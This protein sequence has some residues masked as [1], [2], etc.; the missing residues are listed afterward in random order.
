MLRAFTVE[1]YRSFQQPSTIE[2]RPI[3]LLLGKNSSGKSSLT[4]LTP[5]LQQ[6]LDRRT[7]SPLLWTSDVV[8]F[9]DISNVLNHSA[10]DGM[11]EL[12]FSVDATTYYDYINSISPYHYR[13]EYRLS[14][15][16]TMDFRVK[17]GSTDGRTRYHSTSITI[18]DSTIEIF[19]GDKTI[20]RV[21][22]NGAPIA[23]YAYGSTI[24]AET[25]NLFP[26]V[27]L[28]D[29]TSTAARASSAS[30]L[31]YSPFGGLPTYAG[32]VEALEYFINKKTGQYKRD[33]IRRSLYYV[34]PSSIRSYVATLDNIVGSKLNHQN[35]LNA[36]SSAM[37]INDFPIMMS[38]V[39]TRLRPFFE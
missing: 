26:T 20:T 33:S 4:R 2:L 28:R 31:Y 32:L 8:D 27:S 24:F 25:S 10:P 37:L 6:S 11:V 35:H 7:A 12:T 36:L 16:Q 34:P 9:G 19:W 30:A 17:L 29:P 38:Y 1:N 13:S 3:T 39:G 14:P 21:E 5:L 18:E 15:I 22:L 23:N